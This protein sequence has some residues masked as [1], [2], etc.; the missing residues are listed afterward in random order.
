MQMYTITNQT[1][2]MVQFKKVA[3]I[4]EVVDVDSLVTKEELHEVL[5]LPKDYPYYIGEQHVNRD[6]V[7]QELDRII[8]QLSST[9]RPFIDADEDFVSA[10]PYIY[11][12]D[13][14]FLRR[15]NRFRLNPKYQQKKRQ[16]DMRGALN[17]IITAVCWKHKYQLEVGTKDPK[18]ALVICK[19]LATWK[20]IE[21]RLKT[22][23]SN[24]ITLAK[25]V[26]RDSSLLA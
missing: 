26:W 1:P 2:Y 19:K 24:N 3:S 5:G 13:K 14:K 17:S 20:E 4:E 21:E 22:I 18:M 7:Q 6:K 9:G 11:V 10:L 12:T 15:G 23:N 16:Q 8:E 25:K